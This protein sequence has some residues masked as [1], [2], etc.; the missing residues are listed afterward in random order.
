MHRTV[1]LALALAACSGK[2]T[3]TEET[4]TPTPTETEDSGTPVPVELTGNVG[5][6]YVLESLENVYNPTF[7]FSAGLFGDDDGGL[8]NLSGC[9]FAGDACVTAYPAEGESE[10]GT[11]DFGFFYS[12]EYMDVGSSVTVDDGT[13]GRLVS[14][15]L[16]Y[17]QGTPSG[18]G[19]GDAGIAYDGDFAAYTGTADFTYASSLEALSPSPTDPLVIDVSTKALEFTWTPGGVGDMLF[20]ANGTVIH[21]ADDG[22]E[23][24]LVADLGFEAP[25]DTA[26]LSLGRSTLSEIDANGNTIKIQTRSNQYYYATYTDF[27]GYTEL[28]DGVTQADDCDA[29]ALLTPVTPGLYWGNTAN[30]G[31][32]HDLGAYNDV[33][34]WPSEGDDVVVPVALLD[35]QEIEVTYRQ[36]LDAAVYLLPASCDDDDALDGADEYIYIDPEN[37]SYTATEDG[38]YYL[39]LDGYFPGGDYFTVDIQVTGP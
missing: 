29:A 20:E 33:I 36:V 24:V 31:D 25:L 23:S 12:A 26:T 16:F 35:G 17:Y 4:G 9:I 37:F 32:D 22:S 27:T 19:T 1:T 28:V 3:P 5:S 18:F 38:T 6:V 8:V 10:V 7:Y 14:Q 30:A 13:M 34:Y 39:V 15:G 21:L 11:A 2:T